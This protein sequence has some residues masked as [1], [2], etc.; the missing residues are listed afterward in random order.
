MGNLSFSDSVTCDTCSFHSARTDRQIDL[1]PQQPRDYQVRFRRDLSPPKSIMDVNTSRPQQSY[2]GPKA[3]RDST[4]L[5]SSLQHY[6]RAGSNVL[7]LGCGQRDQAKVFEYLQC[8]YVGIDLT[9][10]EADI[11]AD[12]HCLPFASNSFDVVF[13][14]AVLQHLHNPF[15]AAL[16]IGRVLRP[17]GVFCGTVSQGEPFQ[18]SFFHHTA[19]GVAS[20]AAHTGFA[21][22]RLWPSVDTLR[23][24]SRMGRYPFPI[25]M[26]F[27]VIDAT[28]RGLPILAPRKF[29]SWSKKEKQWDELFRAGSICFLMT[30]RPDIPA[31]IHN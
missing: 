3:A 25:R 13:S 28:Q 9:S 16:E 31:E 4:E 11:A 24:L 2:N 6:L 23:A 26:A 21:I 30:K 10:K 29:F 5:I 17:G 7:D 27:L 8:N 22:E 19:W 15:V 14:Y 20:L 12:A 18:A 1:L